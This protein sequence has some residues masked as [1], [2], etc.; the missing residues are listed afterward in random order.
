M[1]ETNFKK[2]GHFMLSF[3]AKNVC[4]RKASGASLDH[5]KNQNLFGPEC[6]NL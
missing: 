3:F 4:R 2:G 5:L 6:S 1:M